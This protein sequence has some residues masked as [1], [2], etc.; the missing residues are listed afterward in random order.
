[1]L[2][3]VT[4]KSWR[5]HLTTMNNYMVVNQKTENQYKCKD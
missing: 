3:A 2:R 4:N 5:D 1:M